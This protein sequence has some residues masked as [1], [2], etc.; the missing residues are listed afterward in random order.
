M[1]LNK[2]NT[3]DA[4]IPGM[5]LTKEL[6]GRPWQSPPQYTTADEVADFY[7]ERMSSE[8]FMLQIVDVLEMGVPVTVLANTIQMANVMDGVHSIDTGM[9][10][11]PLIMEMMMMLGDSAGIKYDS[12][13]DNPKKTR[14]TLLHKFAMEYEK[15]LENMEEDLKDRKEEEQPVEIV[16]DEKPTGLMARRK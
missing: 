3:F 1:E 10:A 8:D 5:S 11:L 16:E 2:E 7:M 12:G 4:P 15:K 6:G 9:L 13:L 14:D